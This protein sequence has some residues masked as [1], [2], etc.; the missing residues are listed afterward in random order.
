[1]ARR[2]KYYSKAR[3]GGGKMK[4]LIDGA[5]AGA[6]DQ[7]A[8]QYIPIPGAGKLAIGFFRRNQTLMTLGGYELVASMIGGGTISSGGSVR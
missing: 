2:K 3:Y 8:G 1:M 5:L 4:G 7:F 6:V